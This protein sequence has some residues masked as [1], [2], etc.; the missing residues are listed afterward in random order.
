MEKIWVHRAVLS[1]F[2]GYD[3]DNIE[4]RH[5]N[6]NPKDNTLENLKWGTRLE[7]VADKRRNG[8]LPIGERSGSHKLT[9]EQVLDIKK[10]HKKES[11]RSLAKKYKVSH[12]CIRRAALGIKWSYLSEEDNHAKN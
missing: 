11:L 2:Y 6:D 5:L 9:E 3:P 1:A 12:T 7:N 8:R 10:E 4:C